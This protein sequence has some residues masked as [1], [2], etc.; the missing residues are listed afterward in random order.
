MREK[1]FKYSVIHKSK[2]TSLFYYF[3]ISILVLATSSC[4]IYRFTDASVD[5]NWKTFSMSQTI[6]IATLQ[7]PNAAPAFT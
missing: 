7:N 2:I 1:S 4:K 3:I 6:N 5:P